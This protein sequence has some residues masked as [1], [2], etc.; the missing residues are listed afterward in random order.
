[1]HTAYNHVQLTMQLNST[2]IGLRFFNK[3]SP[4]LNLAAM[5]NCL[6]SS[7]SVLTSLWPCNKHCVGQHESADHASQHWLV[8]FLLLVFKNATF[9]LNMELEIK[10]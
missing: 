10:A 2:L 7:V 8:V 4:H 9:S 6:R 5:S 1:M 3:M